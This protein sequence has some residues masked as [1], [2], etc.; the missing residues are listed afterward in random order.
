LIVDAAATQ[1]DDE[2]VVRLDFIA[3][4]A[5]ELSL[6]ARLGVPNVFGPNNAC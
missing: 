3:T 1:F 5:I 2:R 6:S 4:V